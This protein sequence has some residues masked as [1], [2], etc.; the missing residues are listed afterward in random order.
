MIATGASK[1]Q[2]EATS[3]GKLKAKYDNSTDA[4]RAQNRRADIM[5]T[6]NQPQGYSADANGLP[7]VDGSV[8]NGTVTEGVQ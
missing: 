2:V 3:N 8:Y 7:M 5:F 1:A 4:D 6:A